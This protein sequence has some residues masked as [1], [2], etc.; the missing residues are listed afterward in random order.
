MYVPGG[1]GGF[2]PPGSVGAGGGAEEEC[3]GGKI[4]NLYTIILMY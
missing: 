1:K 2:K 3:G 4:Y